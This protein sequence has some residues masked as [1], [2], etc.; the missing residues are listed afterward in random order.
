MKKAEGPRRRAD[1]VRFFQQLLRWRG[2]NW[3]E[4]RLF[5][6]ESGDKPRLDINQVMLFPGS[7]GIL[8]L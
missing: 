4:T 1:R 2:P 7:G 3:D 5:V 6:E 8:F